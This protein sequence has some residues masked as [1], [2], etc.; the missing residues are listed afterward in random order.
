MSTPNNIDVSLLTADERL[1]LIEQLWDSLRTT[2]EG[3]PVS[4]AQRNELD[5]RIDEI[6][7]GDDT[8][9]SADEAFKRIRQRKH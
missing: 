9:I 3:I 8:G 7:A 6:E 2:P 1:R 4:E 5:R